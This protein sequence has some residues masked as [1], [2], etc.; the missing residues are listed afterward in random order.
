[1]FAQR[2]LPSVAFDPPWLSC[3]S[4]RHVAPHL[5]QSGCAGGRLHWLTGWYCPDL[6][7]DEQRPFFVLANERVVVFFF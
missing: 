2:D 1:M 5:G 4:M 3:T 6:D 7:L